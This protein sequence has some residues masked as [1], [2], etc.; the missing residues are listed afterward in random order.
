M[1][2]R[3]TTQAPPNTLTAAPEADADAAPQGDDAAAP[4][5][6][7]DDMYTAGDA[8]TA[9]EPEPESDG[10]AGDADTVEPALEPE[11][12]DAGD[13]SDTVPEPEGDTDYEEA[14]AKLESAQ[15]CWP[16]PTSRQRV[17]HHLIP[18]LD[19]AACAILCQHT[20]HTQSVAFANTPSQIRTPAGGRR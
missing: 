15:V 2:L 10:A 9:P 4:E 1:H 13:D 3:S 8:D 20:Q 16:A 18:A 17:H 6:G 19:D 11:S 14:A 7:L 12:A 5:S